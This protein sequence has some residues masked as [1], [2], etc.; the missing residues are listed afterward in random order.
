MAKQPG[1]IPHGVI[2]AVLLPFN[3]DLSIDEASSRALIDAGLLPSAGVRPRMAPS[4][5]RAA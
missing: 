4:A 5:S 2:P 1:W 3:E